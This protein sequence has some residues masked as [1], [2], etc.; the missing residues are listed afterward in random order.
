MTDFFQI[1]SKQRR[2]N[3]VIQ[4]LVDM[5]GKNVILYDTC[6][7]FLKTLYL[8]TKNS[9]YCTLRVKIF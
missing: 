3:E 6:L 4:N 7:Q 8:R 1:S 2:Q 5:I 9:H